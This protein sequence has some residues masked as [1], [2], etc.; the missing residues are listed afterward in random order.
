MLVQRLSRI[1]LLLTQVA[2]VDEGIGEVLALHVI[3]DVALAGVAEGGTYVAGVA[4]LRPGR[5]E[6]V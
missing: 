6:L 3:P 1:A 5:D 4:E 2:V